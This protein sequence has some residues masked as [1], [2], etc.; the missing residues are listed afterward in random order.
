[1]KQ[2]FWPG[3]TV[4]VTVDFADLAGAALV[5]VGATISARR[6]DGVVVQG[7]VVPVQGVT[8]SYYADFVVALPGTWAVRCACTGPTAAAVEQE[9]VVAQSLV[10]VS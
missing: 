8:G 2:R 1:M 6:P 3:E 5:P 4:R 9:F 7:T 10:G